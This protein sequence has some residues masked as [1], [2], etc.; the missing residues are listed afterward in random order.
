M[1]LNAVLQAPKGK[2]TSTHMMF[3]NLEDPATLQT[4]T[5]Q[6]AFF[7]PG[8]YWFAQLSQGKG[9]GAHCLELL[10]RFIYGSPD[11]DR[12]VHWVGLPLNRNVA[13]ELRFALG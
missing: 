9:K 12:Y 7:C 5:A 2:N 3:P 11:N 6:T 8:Q 1:F 10:T 4:I 13:P